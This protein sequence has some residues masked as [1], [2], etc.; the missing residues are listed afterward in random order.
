M[1]SIIWGTIELRGLKWSHP[2]YLEFFFY[3]WWPSQWPSSSLILLH[4]RWLTDWLP[5][6]SS[7]VCVR[8]ESLEMVFK[9]I[10][11]TPH[12]YSPFQL[13]RPSS[14]VQRPS[15]EHP[16]HLQPTTHRTWCCGNK[17]QWW[18]IWLQKYINNTS[19]GLISLFLAH[20]SLIWHFPPLPPTRHHCC[21]LCRHHSPE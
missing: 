9:Y 7:S 19:D 20:L 17:S 21:W 1:G 8:S 15:M 4:I 10:S 14:P 3:D 6:Q 11:E 16:P 13:T 2:V 5:H 18:S 12:N